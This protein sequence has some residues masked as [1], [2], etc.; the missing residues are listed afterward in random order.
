MN[1]SSKQPFP[2]ATQPQVKVK[3]DTRL[4]TTSWFVFCASVPQKPPQLSMLLSEGIKIPASRDRAAL[5]AGRISFWREGSTSVWKLCACA[6]MD[7]RCEQHLY[8]LFYWQSG[9]MIRCQVDFCVRKMCYVNEVWRRLQ[10]LREGLSQVLVT[11]TR[12][13]QRGRI[14]NK[15]KFY[16]SKLPVVW[17]IRVRGHQ[18]AVKIQETG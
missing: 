10:S 12:G 16:Q 15:S 14:L 18:W 7:S 17:I 6:I 4:R 9:W 5:S 1:L 2:C 3:Q 11:T 13:R 8:L